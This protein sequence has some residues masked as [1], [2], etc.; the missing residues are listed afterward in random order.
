MRIQ[1]SGLTGK[2]RSSAEGEAEH[3]T[4]LF[5]YTCILHTT[6]LSYIPFFFE[7]RIILVFFFETGVGIGFVI[8]L[9]IH[10]NTAGSLFHCHK[11]FKL[12]LKGGR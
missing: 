9:R 2:N 11:M 3:S 1:W 8:F 12:F 5:E 7:K 6:R 10:H 4:L